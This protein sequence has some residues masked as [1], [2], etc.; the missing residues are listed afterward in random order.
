[1]AEV[2]ISSSHCTRVCLP[3]VGL[4]ITGLGLLKSTCSTERGISFTK[5]TEQNRISNFQ[6][7]TNQFDSI[8]KAHGAQPRPP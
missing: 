8:M 1:M 7:N 2:G 6:G 5:E 4:R 3:K